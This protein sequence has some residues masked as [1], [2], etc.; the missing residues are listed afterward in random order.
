MEVRVTGPLPPPHCAGLQVTNHVSFADILVLSSLHPT[1]FV[2]KSE[3]ASWPIIGP[4][5][6]ASGT[7]FIQRERRTDVARANAALQCAIQAGLRVTLFPEGTSSNGQAVLPF[8]PALLQPALRTGA[9]ITPAFLEYLNPDGSRVD[10][11][12]YF[13]DRHLQDCLW[14]LISRKSTLARVHFGPS[15]PPDGD[16]KSLAQ[17]LHEEVSALGRRASNSPQNP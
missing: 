14:A 13:G 11:I 2:A 1:V 7:I 17:S 16:R 15:R 10:E 5:A 8:Q 6:A 9:D 4:I 12:A 3:V